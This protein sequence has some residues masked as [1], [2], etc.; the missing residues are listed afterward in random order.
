MALSTR[1]VGEPVLWA[2]L[3]AVLSLF[4][5]ACSSAL[6]FGARGA[7]LNAQLEDFK[8][9]PALSSHKAQFSEKDILDASPRP[10][11]KTIEALKRRL[12]DSVGRL[13]YDAALML[14]GRPTCLDSGET[15]FL[16]TWRCEHPVTVTSSDD[17]PAFSF[18]PGDELELVFA[19]HDRRLVDWRL[20]LR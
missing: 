15:T 14:L 18:R 6:I 10:R 20:R 16:A 1:I 3:L 9:R 12:D 11:G 4:P 19:D 8:E 5:C 17:E 13:D 7:L 2:V